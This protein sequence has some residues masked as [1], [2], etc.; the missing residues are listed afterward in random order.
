MMTVSPDWS[1]DKAA[2]HPPRPPPITA[3]SAASSFGELLALWH[4]DNP[5]EKAGRATPSVAKLSLRVI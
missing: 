1:A 5:N 2:A 4:P 3:K